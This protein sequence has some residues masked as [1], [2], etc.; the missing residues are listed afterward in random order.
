MYTESPFH[1]FRVTFPD[2]E[3][4]YVAARN[5]TNALRI[6]AKG[7]GIPYTQGDARAITSN[8]ARS[9]GLPLEHSD[10]GILELK[11]ND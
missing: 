11:Q 1:T 6:A 4:C 5:W 2:R 10:E 8:I 9:L 7:T 3:P